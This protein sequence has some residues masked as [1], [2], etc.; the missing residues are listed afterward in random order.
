MSIL[1]VFFKR[2]LMIVWSHSQPLPNEKVTFTD[3]REVPAQSYKRP[4]S[5]TISTGQNVTL[6]SE[7]HFADRGCTHY[8]I[9]IRRFTI[10][11]SVTYEWHR[12]NRWLWNL[13]GSR[14]VYD[15]GDILEDEKDVRDNGC[16]PEERGRLAPRRD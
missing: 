15:L 5:F 14:D 6:E 3:R 2:V 8:E 11:V 12:V 4:R 13:A 16:E 10:G 1:G 7:V 9:Q